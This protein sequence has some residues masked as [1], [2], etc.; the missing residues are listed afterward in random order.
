MAMDGGSPS[1]NA[2]TVVIVNCDR[3]LNAPV[4]NQNQYGASILE[5]QDLGVSFIQISGHDDDNQVCSV[6]SQDSEEDS[7]NH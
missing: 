7:Q 6:L 1:R 5:T 3:N 4:I 2:T